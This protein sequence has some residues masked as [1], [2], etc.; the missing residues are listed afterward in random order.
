M[1]HPK[2]QSGSIVVHIVTHRPDPGWY[3]VRASKMT[4]TV[5]TGSRMPSCLAQIPSQIRF[6]PGTPSHHSTTMTLPNSCNSYRQFRI[7]IPIPMPTL[8]LPTTA[9]SLRLPLTI[10]LLQFRSRVSRQLRR[11]DTPYLHCVKRHHRL[12]W[13]FKFEA[14]LLNTHIIRPSTPLST[15]PA[16]RISWS[17]W[18]WRWRSRPTY[19]AL[20]LYTRTQA[21]PGRE[22]SRANVPP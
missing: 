7:W 1:L 19:S 17:R 3:S 14:I 22:T 2:D 20:T 12:G 9:I 16:G 10:S 15:L 6:V 18:R 5:R 4:K 8:N 11:Q 13:S 21:S